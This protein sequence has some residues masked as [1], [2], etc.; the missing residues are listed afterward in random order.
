MSYTI[1]Q[2]EYNINEV[3]N[4]IYRLGEVF[5]FVDVFEIGK[6]VLGRP[7]LALKIGSRDNCILYAAGFHGSER[8]TTLTNLLFVED[9]CTSLQNNTNFSLSSARNALFNKSIIVV[10]VVNPDG[11]EIS[12]NGPATAGQR[13]DSIRQINGNNDIKFWNANANGV[14]INHNFDAGFDK[15]KE[16]ERSQ[17]ITGPAPRR[18]GGTSPESEP[19]TKALVNLVKSNN[20]VEVL[21]WHSQGEEI[22]WQYGEN[23]PEKSYRLA[24]LFETASGY[25]A[26]SPAPS[27]SYAG[28]KDWFV[29][30]TGKPGFTIEIG[31]GQN[32]LDPNTLYSIYEN[33]KELMLISISLA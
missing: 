12:L 28:F 13:A 31:K 23:T 30:T 33:L 5:P 25:K 15:I 9:F 11:Y 32:P 27:A 8:L 24:R 22:Y 16:I 3:I 2:R 20:V 14:D 26:A 4:E 21:A 19:E 6:S 10:P 1:T 29:D 18:Y 7:I 17:G